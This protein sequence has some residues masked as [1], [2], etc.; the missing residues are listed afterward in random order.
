MYSAIVFLPLLGSLIA[1]LFGR[2]IGV[3]ASE[4]VTTGLLFV[5]ALLS[6]VAFS[7]IAIGQHALIVPIATWIPSGDL[8]VDWSLRIDTLTVV[9]LV[10]VTFVS[11]LVH[12]Y[13]MGYMH[14][15]PHRPRFF[16]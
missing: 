9:M 11:S 6:V 10:V 14:E 5:S 12:L 2:F 3:R 13:S 1:G 7:E 8:Y 15:D 16:S 4:I